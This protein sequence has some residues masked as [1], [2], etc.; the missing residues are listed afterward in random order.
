MSKIGGVSVNGALPVVE[1]V[2]N[3]EPGLLKTM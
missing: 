3:I 1:A 2:N